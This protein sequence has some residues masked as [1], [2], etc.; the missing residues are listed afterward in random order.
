M[1]GFGG[2]NL[3]STQAVAIMLMGVVGQIGKP[4]EDD[5]RFPRS[6][7]EQLKRA[8][9]ASGYLAVYEATS[10]NPAY[11]EAIRIY[12][13]TGAAP[14]HLRSVEQVVGFFDGLEA[15]DP[16]I[17]PIQQWRPAEQRKELAD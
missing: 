16:G 11:N 14:Y 8:L 5:D 10:T 7:V 4:E 15:S 3:A 12:N 6:V 2:G 17:V 13:E 9:P 1:L